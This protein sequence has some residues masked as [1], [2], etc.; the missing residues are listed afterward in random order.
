MIE[1]QRLPPKY[2]LIDVVLITYSQAMGA[3]P[4]F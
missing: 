4:C 1:I 3:Y 2:M